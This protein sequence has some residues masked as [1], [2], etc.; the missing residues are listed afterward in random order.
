MKTLPLSCPQQARQSSSCDSNYINSALDQKHPNFGRKLTES[1]DSATSYPKCK[2]YNRKLLTIQRIQNMSSIPKGKDDKHWCL[3]DA[4][5][6]GMTQGFQS[7]SMTMLGGKRKKH[8][9][10]ERKGS[11]LSGP[12]RKYEKELPM[13]LCLPT[14]VWKSWLP[15][16][17]NGIAFGNRTLQV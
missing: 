4:S 15:V 16:P 7:S 5:A 3:G 14:S 10:H 6:D 13:A 9:G 1:R 12:D 8:V 11:T 2:E 17:V